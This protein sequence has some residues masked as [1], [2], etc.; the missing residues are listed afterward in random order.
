VLGAIALVLLAVFLIVE[1]RTA[2]PLV[3][4]RV[5]RQ[6]MLRGANITAIVLTASV[7]PY[8]FF[9]TLYMQ[10][11]LSFSPM[12]SGLGQLPIAIALAITANLTA[13]V[14]ARIGFKATLALGF[15]IIAAG[16][17]WF[18]RISTAEDGGGYFADVFGP[19]VLTG[20]GSGLA[21]V[22]VIIA[23]TATAP[24]AEAGLASGLIQT[25][26]QIGGA[27]GLAILVAVSTNV[28]IG[29]TGA[30]AIVAG[31]SAALLTAAGF[32]LLGAVLAMVLLA[33]PAP[34]PE[35]AVPTTVD[36][37]QEGRSAR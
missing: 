31:F 5:F 35:A 2:E 26:Q 7:F 36:E 23:A 4:L 1:S 3:P 28:A 6:P 32:A 16:M 19:S 34:P 9:L 15:V 29:A 12:E 22:A 18:S 10:Q 30:A 37:H 33:M 25:T 27:V 14:V 17:A 21:F 11:V 24:P 13:K 20:I 8:F